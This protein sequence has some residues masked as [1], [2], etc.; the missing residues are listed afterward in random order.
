MNDE[1]EPKLSDA[2]IDKLVEQCSSYVYRPPILLVSMS[3][4]ISLKERFP[5][6]K[7]D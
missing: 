6:I 3:E 4:F 1:T 5:D 7:I 2:K